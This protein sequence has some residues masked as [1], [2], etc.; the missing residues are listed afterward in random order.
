MKVIQ[1]YAFYLPYSNHG[2]ELQLWN[3]YY[4]NK[5]AGQKIASHRHSTLLAFIPCE[6]RDGWVAR[7]RH[8]ELSDG[9]GEVSE[10]GRNPAGVSRCISL[11]MAPSSGMQWNHRWLWL[12]PG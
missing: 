8:V 9:G 2:K 11:M 4:S 1:S 6:C 12:V 3:I 7:K 10:L 5:A